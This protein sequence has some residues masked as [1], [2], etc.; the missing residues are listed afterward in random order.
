[1][2]AIPALWASVTGWASRNPI[3]IWIGAAILF[4]LGWQKI[5]GDIKEAAK[6]AER[7]ANAIKAA[8][9]EAR[10]VNTI[11]ENSN[12]YVR[13]A[14]RVRGHDATVELPDGTRTLP[15]HHYRD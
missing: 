7:Q 12:E 9:D 1:M 5:K 8:Q 11:M 10:M 15:N 13:E 6:Q 4:F 14:E 3:M 2:F